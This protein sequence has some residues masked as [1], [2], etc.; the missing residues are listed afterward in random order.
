MNSVLSFISD[1]AVGIAMALFVLAAYVA[2]AP[3]NGTP[4][5]TE[6]LQASADVDNDLAAKYAA[7]HSLVA[8][9]E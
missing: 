5:E 1:Q 9:K 8:S 3:P 2:V 4:T 7:Q 6:A